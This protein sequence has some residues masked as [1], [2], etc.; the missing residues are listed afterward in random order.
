MNENEEDKSIERLRELEVE[1]LRLKT[2]LEA[3]K[4]TSKATGELRK[5]FKSAG[6]RVV[7]GKKLKRSVKQLLNELPGNPT[8][9]T[10]A[11]VSTH[12][13]LRLTRIGT[14][15]I[16]VAAAPLLIM[17]IQTYIL[18]LQNEKLDR[19]NELLFW[20]N[21]RLNQQIN[22]EEGNRRS[23]LVFFMSNI[24]DRIEDELRR[25]PSRKLSEPLIARIVSLSQALRPYRYLE[26]DSL[27]TRLLSPERGQLLFSLINSDL[28]HS[29]F[30]KIYS[31]ANFSF[32]D[33]QE[34]NF[35]DAYLK[36]AK[37]ANSYF[38]KANFNGANLQNADLTSA[39]LKESSFY[40]TKMD[41]AVLENA[42]LTSSHM[43]NISLRGGNLVNAEMSE[44]H[45]DGDFSKSNL[46][47]V[48]VRDAKVDIV[49]LDGCIFKSR[50]W[51]DSLKNYNFEKLDLLVEHYEP[52]P[53]AHMKNGKMDT[54]FCLQMDTTSVIRRATQC[55][56]A[57]RAI[58][59]ASPELK[60]WR[61]EVMD[62]GNEFSLKLM[63]DPFGIRQLGVEK[64]SIYLFE[65]H[66][67]KENVL[68]QIRHVQFDPKRLSLSE[69]TEDGQAIGT[70]EIEGS[71][72]SKFLDACPATATDG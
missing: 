44:I 67:K 11:E 53:I 10:L 52:M 63:S 9:D 65:V 41:G 25:S 12:L 20:Q 62:E 22:L 54:M 56:V 34:A 47:G 58:L 5:L 48:K 16:F 46:E 66:V 70:Y 21:D 72:L 30:D 2:E 71:V 57:V 39:F 40:N 6:T 64:D 61:E 36:G 31:R 17:G 13:I 18:K 15:A 51:I 19:Q 29:T 23:S 45:L 24:M 4:A 28:H 38:Y 43:E 59:D 50:S 32:A 26:N 14:F 55:D 7:A 60:K 42:N 35:S 33:L 8:K 3:R 27:T 69:I 37:L 68:E 1:V 49:N